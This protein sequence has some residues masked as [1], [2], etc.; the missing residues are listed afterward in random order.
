MGVCTGK[1]LDRK[2]IMSGIIWE[3][4]IVACPCFQT[5]SDSTCSLP[6]GG[7]RLAPPRTWHTY[8]K[9]FSLGTTLPEPTSS[10]S[11]AALSFGAG[12]AAGRLGLPT[13]S[14]TDRHRERAGRHP[15]GCKWGTAFVTQKNKA[16]LHHAAEAHSGEAAT[17]CVCLGMKG[18]SFCCGK[19]RKCSIC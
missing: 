19:G 6:V 13:C 15:A 16:L 9:R 1:M 12:S 4:S 14:G 2:C 5:G 3:H 8:H 10:S 11:K 7:G 18:I 17:S